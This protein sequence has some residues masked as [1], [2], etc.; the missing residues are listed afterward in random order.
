MDP[1]K[2]ILGCLLEP[3]KSL[4][5]NFGYFLRHSKHSRSA[6]KFSSYDSLA[7]NPQN[8]RNSIAGANYGNV[9]LFFN[10]AINICVCL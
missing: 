9:K 4:T 3:L 1:I 6:D 10:Y 2:G 7:D 5:M 8:R